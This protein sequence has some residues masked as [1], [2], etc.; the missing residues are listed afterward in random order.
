MQLSR[1]IDRREALMLLGA[2]A[3]ALRWGRAEAL[4][5]APFVTNDVAKLKR[6]LMCP[7]SSLDY[8]ISRSDDDAVP[9]LDI[10]IEVARAEH[11]E[12]MRILRASGAEVLLVPD[13]LQEAIERAR[14]KGIWETWLRS[15][16]PRLSA[17][18]KTVTAQVLLGNDPSTQ[19]R[20]WPDGSYRH[21][22][23]GVG[24]F[25]FSRDTAVTTPKGIVL[26]NV[27]NPNRVREQVLLRFI[28]AFA[29]QL[30]RY[31]V[32]FDAQQEGLLAEGGDFQLVDEHTLF[33]GVG[34]RTDPRIAPILARRL[35]MDVL[36]VQTRKTDGLRHG[37]KRVRVR[38]VFLHLDTYFTHL[39]DKQALTL[40]WFLEAAQAGKD[41]YTQFLKG[42]AA[43]GSISDDELTEA[44]DFI[45][46]F[47]FLR[48]YRA[49]SGEEDTSV[50]E[51]KLVDYVRK[52]GYTVHFVGGEPPG[53]DLMRHLFAVV[54]PEHQHQG[55][56]VVA[57]APGHIVAYEG[58]PHTH[59]AL[60]SAGIT[61]T[62]FV[63]RELWPWNGGPHCLTMPLERG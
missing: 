31:P 53:A 19:Y 49:G 24:A 38:S 46:D 10:D 48:L 34:N 51:M 15:T 9:I 52:A 37:E 25:I 33:L 35:G 20:T 43:D 62:T 11:A 16:H 22:I 40:P 45:R 21:I 8:P 26:L 18:P 12:L 41:P 14:S 61:V 6:V 4:G 58:S 56:N 1:L 36:T 13:L 57:T 50:K 23:D 32:V 29:P 3:G 44:R 47:G 55:A 17:D 54:L 39:G 2:G 27:G 5:A 28:F 30:E 60:R 7:P 42:M 63:A 59:A